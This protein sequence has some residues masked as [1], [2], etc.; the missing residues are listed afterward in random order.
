MGRPPRA[1]AASGRS[2][3]GGRAAA[4]CA[5]NGGC[6]TARRPRAG[7]GADKPVVVRGRENSQ[8]Q[9]R[10]KARNQSA[11]RPRTLQAAVRSQLLL[12]SSL[13]AAASKPEDS[14]V[15]CGTCRKKVA[16]QRTPDQSQPEQGRRQG[17]FRRAGDDQAAARR[18]QLQQHRWQDDPA[19]QH[20]VA[21][22]GRRERR[23]RRR[24]RRADSGRPG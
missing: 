8:H 17:D 20:V 18:G 16:S 24:G 11:R 14:R 12:T 5:S 2:A 10:P 6:G 1:I 15:C 19:D 21:P 9:V 23:R 4:G 22:R 13:W 3:T 7:R